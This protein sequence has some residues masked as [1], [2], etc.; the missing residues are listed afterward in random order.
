MEHVAALRTI[1]PVGLPAVRAA[2]GDAVLDSPVA[3]EHEFSMHG[4][5]GPSM[6]HRADD[7]P[8]GYEREGPEDLFEDGESLRDFLEIERQSV[9]DVI[10]R[11]GVVKFCHECFPELADWSS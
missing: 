6:V 7:S 3:I 4:T 9:A 11:G 10:G 8:C 1:Q 5:T 2:L